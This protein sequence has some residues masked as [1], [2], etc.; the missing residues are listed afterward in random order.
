MDEEMHGASS[1]PPAEMLGT[2]LSN[3]ELLQRLGGILGGM[4]QSPAPQKAEEHIE[5]VANTS[6]PSSF[7][8]DGLSAI[9]SNPAMMEKLPQIMA[10]MKPMLASA[11][12]PK[13]SPTASPQINDRERL[14]L[15]LKPFL[16]HERC[17][18]VDAILHISRLGSVFQQLK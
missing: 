3:P 16:S 1:V 6:A 11:P 18:A 9:L 2:L 4:M 13:P 5:T 12:P 10:M 17:E 8:S 14:L 15:A 7:P